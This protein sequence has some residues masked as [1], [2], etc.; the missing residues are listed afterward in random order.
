MDAAD[1]QINTG[2][3]NKLA[4][5][6]AEVVKRFMTSAGAMQNLTEYMTA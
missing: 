3:G 4:T 5:P 2:S 6:N 1:N